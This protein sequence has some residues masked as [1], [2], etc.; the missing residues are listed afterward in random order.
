MSLTPK[1][2]AAERKEIFSPVM[3]MLG[4]CTR[5]VQYVMKTAQY[6]PKFL[7]SHLIIT[8]IKSLFLS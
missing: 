4:I 3:K 6:I 8:L 5:G 2:M 1:E 7:F